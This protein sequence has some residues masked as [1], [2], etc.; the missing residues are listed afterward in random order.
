MT[1][2]M[3]TFFTANLTKVK[4]SMETLIAK[5]RNESQPLLKKWSP[6]P[7]SPAIIWIQQGNRVLWRCVHIIVSGYYRQ[8][9]I[10][11]YRTSCGSEAS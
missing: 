3:V 2:L 10:A 7:P 1:D 8:L 4:S 5:K 11:V 6:F 9:F